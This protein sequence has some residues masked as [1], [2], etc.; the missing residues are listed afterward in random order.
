VLL[1]GAGAVGSVLGF[2]LHRGGAKVTYLVRPAHEADLRAGLN[3]YPVTGRDWNRSPVP[4]TGFDVC[5]TPPDRPWDYVVLC[6]SSTALRAGTWFEELAPRI[7][8]AAVV[9]I[10]PGA[11]DYA[12]VTAR[13]PP[14]RV[15]WGMFALM[16]WAADPQKDGVP[17]PGFAY[18]R[19]PTAKLA[20]SGLRARRFAETLDRGGMPS[21]AIA[22]VQRELAFT[23]PLLEV[24]TL[25][26]ECGGWAFDAVRKDD[27]LLADAHLAL[28]DSMALAEKRHGGSRPLVSRLLR[29]WMSKLLLWLFPYLPPFDVAAFFRRHYTKVSDQSIDLLREKIALCQQEGI[30][31]FGLSAMLTRLEARRSA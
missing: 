10:Q 22:D 25:A 14:A 7:G 5:T 29:P 30:G 16:S 17:S 4:F 18:W 1:V 15:I 12:F 20:W 13:I 6:T 19:P 2:H 24:H 3:M 11:H 9:A 21:N 27:A 26:L 28:A 31:H 23:G 8:D